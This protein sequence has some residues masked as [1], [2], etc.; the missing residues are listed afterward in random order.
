MTR[1]PF[2]GFIRPDIISNLQSALT[3]IIEKASILAI[4]LDSLS[5]QVDNY[6]FAGCHL[7]D[8]R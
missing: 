4:S 1:I 6:P 5:G 8:Y 2:P 7:P 3:P